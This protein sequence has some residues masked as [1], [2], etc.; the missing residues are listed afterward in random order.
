MKGGIHEHRRLKQL[1][2]DA[3]RQRAQN[4][5]LQASFRKLALAQTGTQ[6]TSHRMPV[7]CSCARIVLSFDNRLKRV[8]H[9]KYRALP[10]VRQ[11]AAITRRGVHTLQL[12]IRDC[13][14]SRATLVG[15]G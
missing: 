1:S 11:F 9:P 15:N 3:W 4:S 6:N 13:D 7:A 5:Y 10:H 12:K 8:Q 2:S 14:S